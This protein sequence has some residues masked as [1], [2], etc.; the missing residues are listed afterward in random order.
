MAE[1]S[2]ENEEVMSKGLGWAY[3]TNGIVDWTFEDN[4]VKVPCTPLNIRRLKWDVVYPIANKASDLYSEDLF[5]P[6]VARA[7]K[8]S[9][10]GQTHDST[11]ATTGRSSRRPKP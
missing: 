8:S 7:S 3:V 10:N 4:G 1:I 11:L 6:L 5:R 2:V 9:R